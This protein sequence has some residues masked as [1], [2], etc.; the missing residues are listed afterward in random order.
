MKKVFKVICIIC[1]VICASKYT[2]YTGYDFYTKC[3]KQK[4]YDVSFKYLPNFFEYQDYND[5]MLV[6]AFLPLLWTSDR[7]FIIREIISYFLVILLVRALTIS[8]TILPKTS[9]RC[10]KRNE[11]S[12]LFI[13]HCYDL[14]FSGHFS[15]GFLTT[16]ILSNYQL[17]SKEYFTLYNILHALTIFMTR[18]HYTI[19]VLI[20]G[21]VV[22]LVYQND[23]RAF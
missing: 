8:T 22:M 4:V 10:N 16:M 19:D 23:L 15:L 9:S 2:E 17:I 11:T 5:V 1:I 21:M 14:I 6:F 3:K 20:A 12:R 7:L 13:G 18:S